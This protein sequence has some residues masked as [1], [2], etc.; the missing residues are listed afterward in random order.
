M[1][2]K[3]LVLEPL[4]FIVTKRTP[5]TFTARHCAADRIYTVAYKLA[6]LNERALSGAATPSCS[7]KLW[8]RPPSRTQLQHTT[9][10]TNIL[11]TVFYELKLL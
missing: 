2:D 3:K 5:I 8:E 1:P 7:A 9:S 6:S 10:I 11:F 4:V